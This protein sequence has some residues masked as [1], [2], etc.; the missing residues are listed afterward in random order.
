MKRNKLTTLT[1][2]TVAGAAT[3]LSGCQSSGSDAATS[4]GASSSAGTASPAK[5]SGAAKVAPAGDSTQAAAGETKKTT[6]PA[7]YSATAREGDLKRVTGDQKR[8]AIVQVTS[9]VHEAASWDAKG[10]VWFWRTAGQGWH[11]IGSSRYP[12]L[13]G[14]PGGAQ[15]RIASTILP[16]MQ[17]AVYL[18]DGVFTGDSSGNDIAFAATSSGKWG[19]V[20]P[21][22][23]SLVPTGKPATDNTTP[24]IWRDARFTSGRMRTTVG[25]P[26]TANAAASTYPLITDW[27]WKSGKFVESSSNG[28]VSGS[29]SAPRTSGDPLR[30]CPTAMPDGS[31]FG[32]VVGALPSGGAPYSTVAMKFWDP[33]GGSFCTVQVSANTPVTTP[34]T[35][36][37]G[38]SWVTVPAWMLQTTFHQGA[39]VTQVYPS[40]VSAGKSPLV[41]PTLRSLRPDLG[42]SADDSIAADVVVKDGKVTGIEL[43]ART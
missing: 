7:Q 9:G 1:V 39:G 15:T 21:Q 20:A 31:Y 4:K 19:T 8:S 14:S 16:G 42:S 24:G 38:A 40:E 30:D 33:N 36:T 12:T 29:V 11:K 6:P 41:A 10:N 3:L 22:G 32:G 37:S 23:D 25:N 13:P 35:T 5:A 26:F 28:F 27:S 2:V 17:H 34:A 43:A 18:A